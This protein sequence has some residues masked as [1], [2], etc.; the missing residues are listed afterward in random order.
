M[1]TAT[2]IRRKGFDTSIVLYGPGSSWPPATR[3][4]PKVGDEAFPGAL[5]YNKQIQ[6]FMD[7]GG[8]STPAASPRPRSTACARST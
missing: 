5:G 1:L 3:G 6:T 8:Q 2:R 7:E 4:Y